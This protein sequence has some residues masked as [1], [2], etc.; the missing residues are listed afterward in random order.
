MG[1]QKQNERGRLMVPALIAHVVCCGGL[2]LV[3]LVGSAG[4]AAIAAFAR[5]PVVQAVALA[6]VASLL[7]V[8]WSRRRSATARGTGGERSPSTR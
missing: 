5:D 7:V 6:G 2:L 3:V 1:P 4:F 8:W